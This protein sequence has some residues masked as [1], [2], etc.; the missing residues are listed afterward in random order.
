MR[1][2]RDGCQLSMLES[3]F[4]TPENT[5]TNKSLASTVSSIVSSQGTESCKPAIS[6]LEL[7]LIS[8]A[9]H[10]LPRPVKAGILAMVRASL[11][12]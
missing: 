6:D 5:S 2:R 4:V 1:K 10:K 3:R 8:K 7:M 9:W 11:R 12:A